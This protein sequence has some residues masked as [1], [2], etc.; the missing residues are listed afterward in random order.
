[1]SSAQSSILNHRLTSGHLI[2][3]TTSANT[4]VASVVDLARPTSSTTGFVNSA[5][6]VYNFTTQDNAEAAIDTT[7]A[8]G[9]SLVVGAFYEDMGDR[10]VFSALG[11][12][13]A[14]FA[15]VRRLNEIAYEGAETALYTC[16]WAGA[17]NGANT[18]AP[19]IVGVARL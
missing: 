18:T 5:G 13:I 11:Q 17:P 19:M 10:I 8:T 3:L 1:M 2:A 7:F 6:S 9:T 15:K 16:I 4:Y 14:I 12:T